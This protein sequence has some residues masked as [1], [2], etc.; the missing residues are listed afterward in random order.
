[1]TRK[2]KCFS[3]TTQ[4]KSSKVLLIVS[5][6]CFHFQKV[7]LRFDFLYQEILNQLTE[8]P[9]IRK[10]ICNQD[11]IVISREDIKDS[12]GRSLFYL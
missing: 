10:L 12:R 5:L 8:F 4:Y 3:R 2:F 11:D 6:L 9:S 1:M 7:L